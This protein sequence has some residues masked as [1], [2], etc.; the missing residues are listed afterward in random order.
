[1][2]ENFERSNRTLSEALDGMELTDLLQARE[3]IVG[4]VSRYND[5]RSHLATGL[6]AAD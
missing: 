1:V 2:S 3:A 6:S 4:I 5:E